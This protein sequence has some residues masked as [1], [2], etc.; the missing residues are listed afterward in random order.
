MLNRLTGEPIAALA[1]ILSREEPQGRGSRGPERPMGAVGF[2]PRPFRSGHMNLRSR[3]RVMPN[4]RLAYDS[5]DPG[6]WTIRVQTVPV[7]FALCPV[8]SRGR[9]PL[10]APGGKGGSTGG[11]SSRTSS[12]S[13]TGGLAIPTG[14]SCPT[15]PLRANRTPTATTRIISF[16]SMEPPPADRALARLSQTVPTPERSPT[17]IRSSS[18]TGSRIRRLSPGSGARTRRAR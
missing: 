8:Y 16:R 18:S 6:P 1:V 10:P 15:H 14:S 9:S 5:T 4:W 17:R 3:S 12:S 2:A 13:C 11:E 7:E